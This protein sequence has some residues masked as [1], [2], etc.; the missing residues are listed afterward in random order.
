MT[1]QTTALSI[2]SISANDYESP[3][4]APSLR[5]FRAWLK[6]RWVPVVLTIIA[7]VTMGTTVAG[8]SRAMSPID[9]WV[10]LDYLQKVPTQGMVFRGEEMTQEALGYMACDGQAL[11]GR[12]SDLTCDGS[13]DRQQFPY[14]GITSAD[15]Y[16]PLF[17]VPTSLIGYAAHFVTGIDIVA[18]WRW[19]TSLWLVAGLLMFVALLRLFSVPN[20]VQFALGLLIIG[21]PFSYWTYS[22]VSTDAPSLLMGGLLLYLAVRYLR[23]E[24]RPWPLL[25]ASVA[26][27]ALKFP[28]ILGVMLVSLL[29]VIEWIIRARDESGAQRRVWRTMLQRKNLV[30]PM[31]GI[32]YVVSSSLF[33]LVWL[34]VVSLLAVSSE[35]PTQGIGVKV[36]IFEV[37]WLMFSFGPTSLTHRLSTPD[38]SGF[39]TI[40]VPSLAVIPLGW[41]LI[42]GILAAFW[43]LTRASMNRALVIAIA[44]SVVALGIVLAIAIG[45]TQGFYFTLGPRYAAIL[46][47]GLLLMVA[48][49]M[50]NKW[51]TW[52]IIGY[53]SC[54][55]LSMPVASFIVTSLEWAHG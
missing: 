9:E 34:R 15:A 31:W 38:A 30:L 50:R 2:G 10:Y 29:F 26:A 13:Y 3:E 54:L 43:G 40:P 36:T 49:Q 5:N 23:G 6:F 16:T 17:F 45:I 1:S 48:L 25:L 44:I 19:A 51:A 14:T 27:V 21:A 28:F 24:I 37:L 8:H 41:I 52:I 55:A 11:Q 47:I 20:L 4:K 12:I 18:A 33:V 32:I 7:L 22:Y 39:D 42:S 46:S 53:A 35:L